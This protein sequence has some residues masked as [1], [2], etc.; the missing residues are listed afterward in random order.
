MENHAGHA[1]R[2]LLPRFS[3]HRR[4][5]VERG[6]EDPAG[7]GAGADFALPDWD[8][9]LAADHDDVHS[10]AVIELSD[11]ATADG[12]GG[13][14]DSDASDG[15]VPLA[16][17]AAPGHILIDDIDGPHPVILMYEEDAAEHDD[18]DVDSGDE[19]DPHH[20]HV[21]PVFAHIGHAAV[22]AAAIVEPAEGIN[23]IPPVA[24]LSETDRART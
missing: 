8:S 6:N 24:P 18:P 21:A 19:I 10:A 2:I 14:S 20:V 15:V 22:A 23:A 3:R 13:D 5:R 1:G 9:D 16:V 12:A 17:D 7:A 11:A 4:Q